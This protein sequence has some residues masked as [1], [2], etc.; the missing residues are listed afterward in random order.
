MTSLILFQKTNPRKIRR[1]M[2]ET[3]FVEQN[4]EKWREFEKILR[5]GHGDPERIGE[6]FVQINDDLSHA[7]TFYPNRSVRVYLNGL[8]QR[9]FLLVYREQKPGISRVALFWKE[10]LPTLLYAARRDMGIAFLVFTGAFLIGVLS[11]AMDPSFA[12][13]IL[14]Q[15]YV[16]MTQQFIESGDPMAVYKQSGPWDMSLG[17]AFNNLYVACL[18]FILGIFYA[19]GSLFILVSNGIMVGVFQY[20]FIQ[21]GLFLESFLTIWIHGTLEIS[22]IV[23]AAGAGITMG[24]G[25]AFPGT[26]SRRQAFQQSARRGFK[27]LLGIAP[28]ILLAA[29]FEGFLTRHTDTNGVIRAVFIFVCLAFVL[30]YFVWYPRRVA[31]RT[32]AIAAPPELFPDRSEV[33][34]LDRIRNVGD[35][36]ADLFFFLNRSW[37]TLIPAAGIAA[38]VFCTPLI[39]LGLKGEALF[40]Q[41]NALFGSVQSLAFFYDH[42]RAGWAY[43]MNI[44][45]LAAFCAMVFPRIMAKPFPGWRPYLLT[46]LRSLLPASLI[47]LGLHY[48]GGW[49]LLAFPLLP[50]PMLWLSILSLEPEARFAL[51]L[52]LKLFLGNT[53]RSI[54]LAFLLILVGGLFFSLIGAT[55]FWQFF[56]LLGWIVRLS[57]QQAAQVSAAGLMYLTYAFQYVWIAFLASGFGLLYHSLIEITEARGLRKQ[58]MAI[59]TRR[60]IRGIEQE[61]L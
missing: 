3:S 21:Q 23:L 53:S 59:G 8:A 36:F 9:I 25:L 48:A 18:S 20:F 11:C 10:E 22:A 31:A 19:I 42:P 40:L 37:S 16:E 26:F 7:R 51:P 24:R 5:D 30:V 41:K 27:I 29:V 44:P 49:A 46:F 28:L 52:A 34:A 12:E 54:W 6:L 61:T 1:R 50:I 57:E 15:T 58:V 38:L 4:T 13:Q 14:G 47:V 55:L 2:R 39:I 56:N 45:I 32:G 33:P 35:L 60:Q 43:W 17:I